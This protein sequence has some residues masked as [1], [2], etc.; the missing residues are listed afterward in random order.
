VIVGPDLTLPGH[1]EIFV[2]GDTAH[3]EDSATGKPVPGIAPAAKQQGAYAAAAIR[4]RLAG[5]GGK[6]PPFR[7]RHLGNLA[8]IGRKS[9]VADFGFVRLSGRVAWLLWGLVHIT[10]LIGFRNRI[11]VFMNWAWAWLTYGRGA[12]LITT[13]RTGPP[14]G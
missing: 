13:T 11:A 12:R 7:Y 6:V 2:V 5:K 4:A 10:F 1:P 3:V 9:A 14:G 8:T